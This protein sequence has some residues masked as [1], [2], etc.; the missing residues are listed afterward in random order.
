MKVHI[1]A[2]YQ[3]ETWFYPAY[4]LEGQLTAVELVTRFA[5]DNAP[6][7]LPL[8]LLLPQL[9]IQQQ[10]RLLQSQLSLLEKY[11]AFFEIN[12]IPALLKIDE[13]LAVA[14]LNNDLLIKKITQL[15]FIVLDI[16]ETFPQLSVG[17]VHPVLSQLQKHCRL[18]LSQFGAGRV[19]PTAVYDSL[20][21][22]LRLDKDF[23]Q[24][25][26][27][28]ASFI[29]FIQAIIDNFGA[30][31]QQVIICGIDNAVLLNKISALSGVQMQGNHF[32]VVKAGRLEELNYPFQ[33]HH[34]PFS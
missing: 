7:T 28:R 3:S 14:L 29:P 13:A 11:R 27:K 8:D 31:V 22:I 2:D 21:S 19:P 26:A 25:L 30:C 6:V 1:S 10:Q 12:Q 17:K 18:S 32:P 24:N 23:I 9:N 5:H 15:P 33:S 20:F 16:S 34:S 4:T